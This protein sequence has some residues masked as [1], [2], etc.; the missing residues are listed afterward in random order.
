M[1]NF[2]KRLEILVEEPSMHIFLKGLLPRVLPNNWKLGANCFIRV[3]EGKS[4]LQKKLPKLFKAY[5]YYPQQVYVLILH[6]QDGYDCLELKYKL[7]KRIGTTN[8]PY[9]IRIACREL[10]NWYL[11]DLSSIEQ[12]YPGSNALHMINKAKFREPD[13]LQGTQELKRFHK[14]FSKTS[15]ARKFGRVISLNVNCSVSFQ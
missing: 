9:L 15:A 14:N 2:E 8:V 1:I 3:H 10:E 12:I 13:R 4:D 5:A 7:K 6:D 11:G